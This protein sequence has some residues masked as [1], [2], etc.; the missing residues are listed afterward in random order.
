MLAYHDLTERAMQGTLIDNRNAIHQ[1]SHDVEGN[2]VGIEISPQTI[3]ERGLDVD[4][5]DPARGE[6]AGERTRGFHFN[7][8]DSNLWR[9]RLCRNRDAAHQSTTADGDDDG[10]DRGE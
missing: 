5:H 9:E 4:R 10:I 3:R 8:D 2:R 6:A 7:T 1:P